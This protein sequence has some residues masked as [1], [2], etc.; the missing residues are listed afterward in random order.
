MSNNQQ[1][2]GEIMRTL[3]SMDSRLQRLERKVGRIDDKLS[4]LGRK[5]DRIGS[6]DLLVPPLPPRGPANRPFRD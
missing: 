3:Q 6:R 5:I 1:L 2:L 4:D